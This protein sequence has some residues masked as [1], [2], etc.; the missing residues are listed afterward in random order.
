MDKLGNFIITAKNPAG[1]WS[2]PVAIQE[3]NG[4]DPSLFFDTTTNK[5]YLLYNSVA[6]NNKPLCDGHRTIRM[7]EFDIK[8]LKVIGEEKIIVNG[9]TDLSK[10]PVWIE[11]PHLF[12]KQYFGSFLRLRR[13]G[14]G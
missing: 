4:I 3:I 1:P 10:K 11:C 12:K 9:G 6:P 13:I 8:H 7:V 2:N 14:Y 5:T